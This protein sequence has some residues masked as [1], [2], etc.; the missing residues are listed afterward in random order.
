VNEPQK[1]DPMTPAQA[2]Q[3]LNGLLDVPLA[4]VAGSVLVVLLVLQMVA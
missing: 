2:R 4:I 3:T 1:D